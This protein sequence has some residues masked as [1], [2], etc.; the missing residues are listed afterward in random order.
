VQAIAVREFAP[1][2][3]GAQRRLIIVSDLL[4]HTPELSLYKAVPD[5]GA[6]RRS[7]YGQ[8]VEC[9]LHGVKTQ[10]HRLNSATAKRM[11]EV[12]PFW[13]DWLMFQGADIEGL[14]KVPG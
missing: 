2:K 6:F 8:R 10:V 3:E 4:Q 13:L 5:I 7:S 12:V 11:E 14:F 1:L 9:D